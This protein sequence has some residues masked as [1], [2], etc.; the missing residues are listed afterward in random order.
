MNW[1]RERPK[2]EKKKVSITGMLENIK[3][4]AGRAYGIARLEFPQGR[5][6]H[7]ALNKIYRLAKEIQDMLEKEKQG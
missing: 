4:T 5:Y 6:Y 1:L 2:M 3:R 7:D